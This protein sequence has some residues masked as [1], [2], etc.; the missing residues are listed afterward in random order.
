MNQSPH[1]LVLGTG[2]AGKR[3]AR[4]L[5]QLGCIISV[6]DPRA[7]R[8][9][10][11]AAEGPVRGQFTEMAAALN[12]AAYDGFMVASP[13]A[14]HVEQVLEVIRAQPR[15]VLCEKPLSVNA[16]EARRLLPVAN[17]V[18]LAYTY[19]WWPPV[20]EFRRRL[21]AGDIGTPRHLRFVM[22]AHLADWHP[23][24]KYQDFFMANRELGGG[25]LL[26]ESHFVDLMLWMLGKPE[27]L[28]ASVDKI[29]DLEINTDDNVDILVRYA[30]GLRVNL[31]LDLIGRPYERS[32][33]AVGEA[34]T[35][36]W[37]YED[38]N[39]KL[40]KTGER[41][42]QT[43]PFNCERNEMFLG[44]AREF[45]ALI[46]GEKPTPSCSVADGL[47]VLE[48]LDLCRQSAASG[49]SCRL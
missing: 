6:F 28:F 7:D 35:L 41:T 33:T 8:V 17:R 48:M 38:N 11:A 42:W 2:S 23:W 16:T 4:N 39:V 5:R 45:V 9:A 12:A 43:Q 37:S 44:A 31:H 25:A 1:I 3:H 10:E 34:G 46:R 29:S 40:G 27:S 26:D 24:E 30:N 15:W 32:I 36:V 20:I 49:Q 13:P 47:A 19:R 21:L 14:F 22:S 18:L